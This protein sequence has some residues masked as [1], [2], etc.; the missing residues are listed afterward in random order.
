MFLSGHH[1]QQ[2]CRW[3]LDNRYPIRIWSSYSE[4][5]RGDS[6][7]LKVMDIPYFLSLRIPVPVSLVVHNSDESFTD[8]LYTRVKPYVTD[9]SAVNCVSRH[10][11]QLPLGLRDHQYA[12]HHILQAVMNEPAV[13]RDI[14][15]LVNFL[16]ATNSSERQVVYD[17]F[18][19]NRHCLVQS[20]YT[21]F[22]SPNKTIRFADP[23]IQ[24]MR[25]EFYRTLKRCKYALCPPGTGLDTH[26]VY[27]CIHLGVIP[28]VRSSPL[29]S[30]YA[31]MPVKIVKTWEESIPLLEQEARS[32]TLPPVQ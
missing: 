32:G 7:F 14:L 24:R 18:K 1:F 3:N 9:V 17:M 25:L 15:C 10:A 4:L 8:E 30:L 22:H 16:V 6:L 5:K 31:T 20:S 13:P 12:S 19:N 2:Q 27:E 21:H 11:K 26:R 28:I 23:E 29:D